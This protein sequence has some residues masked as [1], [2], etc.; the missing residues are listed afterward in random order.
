MTAEPTLYELAMASQAEVARLR[1]LNARLVE[2]LEEI[3]T[4]SRRHWYE[5]DA[6]YQ[7]AIVARA[8]LTAAREEA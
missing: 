6:A 5:G 7:F 8:A 1:A 2:A 4:Y 3:E